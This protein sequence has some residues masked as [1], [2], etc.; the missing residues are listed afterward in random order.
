MAETA[1]HLPVR[2]RRAA[3]ARSA[4]KHAHTQPHNTHIP[5]RPCIQLQVCP[6]SSPC[7]HTPEHWVFALA[8]AGKAQFMPPTT[9]AHLYASCA[10]LASSFEDASGTHNADRCALVGHSIDMRRPKIGVSTVVSEGGRQTDRTHA[11]PSTSPSKSSSKP[12]HTLQ[13]CH[14]G[15]GDGAIARRKMPIPLPPSGMLVMSGEVGGNA[16][17]RG[18]R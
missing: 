3:I 11:R 12:R 15:Q 2:Y 7:R 10:P 8:Y 16:G 13:A 5:T 4:P 18:R 1:A 14:S 9:E 17:Q 6:G